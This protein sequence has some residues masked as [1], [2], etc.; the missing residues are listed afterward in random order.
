MKYFKNANGVVFAFDHEQI[1]MGCSEGMTPLTE[2]EIKILLNPEQ[3]PYTR[4]EIE[5]LRL[6]AYADPLNGS[7]RYFSEANR[8]KF[9]N[10]PGWESVRDDGVKRYHEIQQQYPWPLAS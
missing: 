9:M 3:T 1:E 8:M 5:L 7:D 6:T 2:E 10:E 4:A